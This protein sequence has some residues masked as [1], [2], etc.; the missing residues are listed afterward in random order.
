MAA[1][2]RTRLRRTTQQR[3]T[4]SALVTARREELAGLERQLQVQAAD[5]ERL[6]RLS[7][8][9]IW[10]TLR[11]NASERLAAEQAEVDAAQFAVAGAEARLASALADDERVSR[12][13]D[14][15]LSADDDYGAAL[16]A[17]EVALHT[18]G[19]RDAAELK[20]IA[21]EVGEAQARQREISE[22]L[23]AREITSTALDTAIAKLGS[24]G[25]WSTYDTFF[26]GG[27]V[28]DVMKHSNIDAATQAFGAV[29]RAL[30]RLAV[31]LTDIGVSSL[32]GVSIS[33]T[34]AIFDVFFD[35]ILSDWMVRE[36]IAQARTNADDLRERLDR[37]GVELG[38]DARRTST[39]IAALMRRREE[40]LT[41]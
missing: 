27:L 28:A 10:A 29:N 36:R 32:D 31:E 35:N 37:L 5:V 22:A 33:D 24:A 21:Q 1:E 11:G 40:I 6:E 13:H 26:G 16:D 4:T 15:L 19:G 2:A 23:E 12:E 9:K 34:L 41:G 38:D 7:T 30:E 14:A 20:S 25:G 17:Y 8:T 18:S 39:R 3:R